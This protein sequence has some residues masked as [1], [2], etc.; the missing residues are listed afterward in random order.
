MLKLFP[1][2]FL[3]FFFF[4]MIRRPPRST[5]FPYTTLF[6]STVNVLDWISLPGIAHSNFRGKLT[7]FGQ[8]R[9]I[10]MKTH[11]VELWSLLFV[12][13]FFPAVTQAQSAFRLYAGVAPTS[14]NIS[15]DN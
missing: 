11:R 2:H 1:I 10:T 4:L 9:S 12:F 5:L 8:G 3:F 15:F 13:A 7:Q 6:R 14:Y